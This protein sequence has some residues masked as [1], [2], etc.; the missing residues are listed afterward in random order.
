MTARELYQAGKLAEAVQ[1][2]NAELRDNP[3]DVKRRTFLFELLC[4]AGNYDRA[5]KQLEI[6]GQEGANAQLG[7]LLYRGAL[8]AERTRAGLFEKEEVA[9]ADTQAVAG[10]SGTWNGR[11]FT[12]IEDADP[13]IGARLEVFAAGQYLWVRLDQIASIEMDPPK[14]LRDLL[15]I[16]ASVR[17]GPAFRGRELGEVLLPVL[18]PFSFREEDDAL[19]LGRATD[20]RELPS[21]DLVPVGQ[22]MFLVDGDPAPILELRRLE[23]TAAAA[24]D[25]HASA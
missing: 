12:A 1:A 3:G 2:L 6:L 8:N 17:T 13:R 23:I 22:R 18:A 15:W 20:W 14:R 5:E 11:P 4:F 21:G 19:K 7:A 9:Q 25:Q 16:P 10:P 24:A